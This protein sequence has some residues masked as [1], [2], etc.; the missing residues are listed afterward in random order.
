MEHTNQQDVAITIPLPD[1]TIRLLKVR[2]S[3]SEKFELDLDSFP[4]LQ[5]KLTASASLHQQMRLE[6]LDITDSTVCV[7]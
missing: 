4:V 5:L 1:G 2:I 3:S 6:V 7:P